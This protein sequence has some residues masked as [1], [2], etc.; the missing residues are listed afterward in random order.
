MLIQFDCEK[1]TYSDYFN[2]RSHPFLE[3]T[4]YWAMRVMFLV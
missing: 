1:N 3:T 2:S 4:Q